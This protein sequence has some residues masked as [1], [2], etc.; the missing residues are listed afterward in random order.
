M[1][2][3]KRVQ[4]ELIGDFSRIH[5][6]WQVLLVGKHQQESVAKFILVQHPL[7]F[8]TGFW[9]SVTVIRVH[10]ENDTLRVL[11]VY[12]Q[13]LVAFTLFKVGHLFFFLT[14]SPKRTNLVLSSHVPNSER[15]V[16]VFNSLDVEAY[17]KFLVIWLWKGDERLTYRW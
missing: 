1:S 8:V 13:K 7:K 17:N 9:H 12:H 14:V 4:T 3:A 15:N 11:E 5:G 16:L 6:I 2:V 10:H